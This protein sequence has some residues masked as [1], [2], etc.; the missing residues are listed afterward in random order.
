M[1]NQE[2]SETESNE[3]PDQE[4]DE[5]EEDDD[6]SIKLTESKTDQTDES[7]KKET[8]AAVENEQY[9]E[10]LKCWRCICM[11]LED[12]NQVAEKYRSSKKKADQEIATLI[13]EQYLPEMPSLFAKAVINN[14]SSK[15]FFLNL[16]FIL[17]RKKNE[18]IVF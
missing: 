15:Q 16:N 9:L 8:P 11:S 6:K 7:I 1:G 4:I 10:E 5:E 17:G 13:D 18:L 3:K 2:E 14:T 12:W